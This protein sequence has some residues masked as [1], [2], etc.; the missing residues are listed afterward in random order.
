MTMNDYFGDLLEI[1]YEI[2]K[3]LSQSTQPYSLHKHQKIWVFFRCSLGESN[4]INSLKFSYIS[5]KTWRRQLNFPVNFEEDPQFHF[6]LKLHDRPYCK[7]WI[8]PSYLKIFF[9][10]KSNQD[11]ETLFKTSKNF[12][13][14]FTA[15]PAVS[16]VSSLHVWRS[17]QGYHTEMSKISL[18]IFEHF[19]NNFF[20]FFN[21]KIK[22]SIIV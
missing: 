7:I 11:N 15:E 21:K 9:S 4:R 22:G 6:I 13:R 1:L 17:R 19:L 3:N 14:L 12:K 8:R 20:L 16:K 5:Y 2:Y 18:N 10:V